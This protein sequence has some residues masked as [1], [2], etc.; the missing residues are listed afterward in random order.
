[1]SLQQRT[2]K[3]TRAK[4]T[5]STDR[6]KPKVDH[7]IGAKQLATAGVESTMTPARILQLQRTVG[8]QAVQRMLA[9]QDTTVQREADEEELQ[10]KADPSAIQRAEP[11][12]ELQM[13]ADPNAIQREAPE[14]ELQMKADP[15]AIQREAPEEELQMKADPNKMPVNVQ[16]KMEGAFNADFSDVKIHEGTQASEVGA[17]AYAQGSNIHFAPGQYDP[18]SKSGQQLLGHELTHVV[19]QRQ[20]AV[21]PTTQVNGVAVN[22][23]PGLEKEADQ[24]GN[25]AADQPELNI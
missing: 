24:M 5:E 14:E 4:T 6:A 10:M 12:E 20:G 11:E 15:S 7:A 3:P 22:D 18:D 17:L 13:K 19:Q 25:K 1:M 16:A 2:Q 23:D 9:N 21:K 8:N